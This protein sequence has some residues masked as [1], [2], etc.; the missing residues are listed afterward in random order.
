MNPAP[1]PV[2]PWLYWALFPAHQLLIRSYFG[3]IHLSGQAHLPPQGPVVLACKHLSRWDPLVLY[4]IIQKPLYFMTDAQQFGPTAQG[5]IMRN[6]GA[7]PV[8]RH[9]P[10]ASSVK[11]AT[12]I[13]KQSQRLVIFPEGG[14]AR[15]QPLRP[16]KLG[17]ARI[18][19]QAETIAQCSIPI[20]PIALR[21]APD[22]IRGAQIWIDIAA[23]IRANSINVTGEKAIARAITDR[24]EECLRGMMLSDRQNTPKN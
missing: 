10:E 3:T 23:P 1:V 13:L 14:I 5:W 6:M 16:L 8:N 11:T 2:N 24:L 9:H 12:A 18:V 7:F 19:L 17:L 15:D 22:A 21:Y 4:F 20:V